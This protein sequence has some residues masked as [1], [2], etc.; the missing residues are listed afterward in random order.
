[1][2]ADN[3]SD[4]NVSGYDLAIIG[5]GAAGMGAAI[6]AAGAGLSVIVLDEQAEPGGQAHRAIGSRAA[7]MRLIGADE[8][9]GLSLARA[10]SSCGAVHQPGTHVWQIEHDS[11]SGGFFVFAALGGRTK[12][13]GAKRLL[14]ATGAIERP[15]PIKGWTLPGV[16]TV[17]AAQIMLKTG[18][19]VPDGRIVIAG[20]GPLTLLYATQ[21]LKAGIRPAAILDTT[22]AGQVKRALRHVPGSLRG[23]RHVLQGLGF[24]RVIRAAGIPVIRGVS[25]I[26]A[27][28]RGQVAGVRYTTRRGS[29]ELAAD[30]V[31]LHEGVVPHT[32]ITM[33]LGADHVWHDG[34]ASWRPAVN[35]D[36]ETTIAGLSVAGD[37]AG[38]GG[39]RIAECDGRLAGL[40]AA[41]A[42]GRSAN[43]RRLAELLDRRRP[44]AAIRPLL[45][46]VYQPRQSLLAPAD[47]VVVC[48]CEEKT[49]ADIRAAIDAGCLGPNQ[50]KSFIRCGMGPCQGR[51]CLATLT[52]LI[53]A[54]RGLSP[55]SV[56]HLR[57]R[58]PLKPITLG[59]L[60]SLSDEPAQQQD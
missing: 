29:A 21:L 34:Q 7:D 37:C 41:K 1:M 28:G 4:Q 40:N 45:D 38:I 35:A 42:L 53:A 51:A 39:W 50:V 26:E 52:T 30:H 23:W 48:R 18:G 24:M 16:M 46:A 47:D 14:V 9:D 58:P 54:H 55:A 19:N 44:H 11:S 56:G 10:F 33:A 17:G 36:G 20:N 13:I 12:R 57:I 49:A 8:R 32:H 31:L 27:T 25:D 22:P 43:P 60:A 59:E 5:A 15:V 3:L 6:E 2:S